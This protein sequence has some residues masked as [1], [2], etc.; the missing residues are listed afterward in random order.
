VKGF[1]GLKVWE[2]AHRLTLQ[3]YKASASFPKEEMYGLTSRFDARPLQSRPILPRDADE[4]AVL[5][6]G[7]FCR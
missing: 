2:K 6:W 3:V 4:T 1:R 7:V 5:N